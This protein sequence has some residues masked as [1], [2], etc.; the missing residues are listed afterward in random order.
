MIEW[1]CKSAWTALR[2]NCTTSIVGRAHGSARAKGFGALVRM[3]FECAWRPRFRPMPRLRRSVNSSMRRRL[4]QKTGSS[5]GLRCAAL[6]PA[7]SQSVEP[8]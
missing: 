7:V 1:S 8:I 2:Q 6:P 3:A 5:A 4:R